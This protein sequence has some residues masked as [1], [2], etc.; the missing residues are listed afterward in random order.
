MPSVKLV[1][2]AEVM[3]AKLLPAGPGTADQVYPFGSELSALK[4]N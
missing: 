2:S 4:V 3:A 1:L